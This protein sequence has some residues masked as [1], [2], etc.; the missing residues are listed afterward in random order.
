[1]DSPSDE[2]FTGFTQSWRNDWVL[3]LIQVDIIVLA[4]TNVDSKQFFS[5]PKSFILEVGFPLI[6][7]TSMFILLWQLNIYQYAPNLFY[8][9]AGHFFCYL[10]VR[11]W[12]VDRYCF[13]HKPYINDGHSFCL[14]CLNVVLK[15]IIVWRCLTHYRFVWQCRPSTLLWVNEFKRL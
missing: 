11:M 9:R 1:M 14:I 10:G 5:G 4:L 6:K 13:L 8:Q 12:I 7:W 2:V 3:C 15:L